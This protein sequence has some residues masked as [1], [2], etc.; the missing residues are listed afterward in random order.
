MKK[1]LLPLLAPFLLPACRSLYEEVK[2][3][4]PD[5]DLEYGPI[6]R[7]QFDDLP[8]PEGF[9]LRSKAMESYSY[10]CGSFRCGRLIY[11]GT[12]DPAKVASYLRERL[13]LHGWE[14][15]AESS[16]EGNRLLSFRK[17]GTELGCAVSRAQRAGRSSTTVVMTVLPASL[18]SGSGSTGL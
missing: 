7:A 4:L 11:D 6:A 9:I 14:I 10:Q 3:P 13:P 18:S 15:L 1:T 12:A 17:G 2:R 8:A 5:V 16:P